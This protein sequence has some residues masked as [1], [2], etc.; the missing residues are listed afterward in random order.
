M[1]IYVKCV[2][3]D[4]FWCPDGLGRK[5]IF[6]AMSARASGRNPQGVKSHVL[7]QTDQIRVQTGLTESSHLRL[8]KLV[9]GE[10]IIVSKQATI[11]NR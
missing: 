10:A 3:T 4:P 5:P 6:V 8:L 7:V 9:F 11:E 1:R 2:W